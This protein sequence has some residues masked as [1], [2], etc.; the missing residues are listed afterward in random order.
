M[1]FQLGQY[2]VAIVVAVFCV[3]FGWPIACWILAKKERNRK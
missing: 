1:F 2:E 3:L